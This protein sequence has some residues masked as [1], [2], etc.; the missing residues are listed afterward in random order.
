MKVLDALVH[1]CTKS[2]F[3]KIK[4][5][6]RFPPAIKPRFSS[7]YFIFHISSLDL[8]TIGQVRGRLGHLIFYGAWSWNFDILRI[9]Q[10]QPSSNNVVII[11]LSCPYYGGAIRTTIHIAGAHRAS[12]R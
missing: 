4:T 10:I 3:G 8:K 9:Q 7:T 6:L 11:V 2:L 5:S 1:F 12:T